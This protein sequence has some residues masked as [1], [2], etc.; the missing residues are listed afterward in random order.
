M[1]TLDLDKARAAKREAKGK[2]STTRFGGK[3]YTI[4]AEM[5]FEV[6]EAI[7]SLAKDGTADVGGP[8]T[9]GAVLRVVRAL[10]GEDY[11]AF[12]ANRPSAAEM[13]EFMLWA[14]GEYG[15]EPGESQ[16]SGS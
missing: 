3:N 15:L 5:P 2:P 1:G 13:N 16:A 9:A 8:A 6:I 7:G 4:P 11:D 12:M 10:L 14:I